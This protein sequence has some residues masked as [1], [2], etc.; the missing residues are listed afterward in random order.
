MNAR[1]TPARFARLLLT[2]FDHFGRH[3]LPWQIHKNPYR[4]WVSE[5]MLQQTQVSTVIPY[6][7]RFITRFPDVETLANAS[8]D[9]VLHYWTGL[10]YYSRAK[11]LKAAAEKIVAHHQGYL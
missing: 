9:D 5:I 8:L 6:F 10:G 2:W 7:N 3:D 1:L 4:V 11:N